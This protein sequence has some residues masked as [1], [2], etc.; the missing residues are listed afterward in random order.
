M[1]LN[2]Y[3]IQ[4]SNNNIVLSNIKRWDFILNVV[5]IVPKIEVPI[6]DMTMK[7]ILF[8]HDEILSKCI[9]LGM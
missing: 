1:K 6:V 8:I 5:V 9:F 4:N 3:S 2:S 7:S